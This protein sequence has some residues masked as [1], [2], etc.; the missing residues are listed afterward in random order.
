MP[1]P[2]D[3]RNPLALVYVRDHPGESYSSIEKQFGITSGV[4]A[5]WVQR[6]RKKALKCAD[7]GLKLLTG[8]ELGRG[9]L[10]GAP[11]SSTPAT[12][13]SSW[14]PQSRPV[15]QKI[16]DRH[17]ALIDKQLEFLEIQETGSREYMIAHTVY[18]GLLADWLRIPQIDHEVLSSNFELPDLTTEEGRARIVAELAGLPDLVGLLADAATTMTMSTSSSGVK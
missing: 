9:R 10:A 4:L 16:L 15:P 7:P 14:L 11:T 3:P 18:R 1:R 5:V 8:G 6:A 2:I 12:L 17:R 13:P